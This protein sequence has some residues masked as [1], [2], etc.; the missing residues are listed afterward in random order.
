MTETLVTVESEQL[1]MEIKEGRISAK[2]ITDASQVH[3][4]EPDDPS[5]P[6]VLFVESDGMWAEITLHEAD[7]KAIIS[8][9]REVVD[10]V[11]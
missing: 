6:A 1:G 5:V 10:D 2:E 8:G 3:V 9:L 4:I 11:R 7:A